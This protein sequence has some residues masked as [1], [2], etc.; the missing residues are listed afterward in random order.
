MAHRAD[1]PGVGPLVVNSAAISDIARS[2]FLKRDTPFKER[3][4]PYPP[5]S[6]LASFPYMFKKEFDGGSCACEFRVMFSDVRLCRLQPQS[7]GIT[8]HFPASGIFLS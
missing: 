3:R 2:P 1:R 6:Q 8:E 5:P 4:P 7:G